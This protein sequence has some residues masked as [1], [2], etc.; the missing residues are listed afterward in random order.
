MDATQLHR[1]FETEK[2]KS[3]KK[4]NL[5]LNFNIIYLLQYIRRRYRYPL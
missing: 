5:D 4:F 2:T 3:H 1:Q